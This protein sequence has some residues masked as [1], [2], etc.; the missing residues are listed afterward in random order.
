MQNL[1]RKKFIYFVILHYQALQVT[2]E[3]IN[4]IKK[5][6]QDVVGI[7]IV[8]VDNASP[9]KSGI[10]L[11]ELYSDDMRVSV[12]INKENN[13]FAKGNNMG[14]AYAKNSGADF[15]VL[16]NNDTLIKDLLFGEKILSIYEENKFGVLGPD[17]LSIK[18]GIHQNPTKGFRITRGEVGKRIV[19]ARLILLANKCGLTNFLYRHR[20]T[21]KVYNNDYKNQYTVTSDYL[22]VLH[23]SCLIF[24]PEYIQVFDGLNDKTFMYYE[25]YILAYECMKNNI[26]MIYSPELA[27]EHYRNVSTNSSISQKDLKKKIN[28]YYTESLKSLKVLHSI[29]K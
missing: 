10:Q 2:I 16:I 3:C 5:L 9:N 8:V 15:I 11:K 13:G 19:K 20:D 14:F 26:K 23:G 6:S 18:D 7:R 4:S 21:N 25:E 28:F 17:I 29:L 27:I 22:Y 24:S 12:I 1:G